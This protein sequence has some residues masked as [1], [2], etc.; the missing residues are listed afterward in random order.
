MSRRSALAACVLIAVAAAAL[1]G[2]ARAQAYPSKPI[3]LVIPFPPGGSTD[4]VGRI[5][6]R[7][8]SEEYGQQVI[9]ENRAGAGGGL[10]TAQVARSEPDGHTLVMVPAGPIT[11][12]PHVNKDIGYRMSDLVPVAMVFRSPFLLVVSAQSPHTTLQQLLERGKPAQGAPAAYGSSGVGA[13][14]H[15]GSEMLNAAA[16]TAFLHVPYK[17]TPG[18]LQALLAGDIQWALVTGNDGKGPVEGGKLRALA[19]MSQKRSALFP[20]V[21]A[22]GELGLK[23]LDLDVWFG[24]FAPA[25]IPAAT[26]DQLNRTVR[27][28]LAEPDF[29]ARLREFGGEVPPE[30]N[31]PV[32][33]QAHLD[34]ESAAFGAIVRQVGVKAD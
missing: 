4:I 5:L 3:R 20:Q 21:P 16:G 10:G 22:M 29:G 18:T 2:A 17:G 31:T 7:R 19:V 9:V 27:R 14:S 32:A 30:P 26:L 1:P 13:L 33:V 25:R 28:I 8:M 15:L 12:I 24:L 23:N 11:V 34:R 6:A